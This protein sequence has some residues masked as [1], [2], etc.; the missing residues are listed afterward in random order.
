MKKVFFLLSLFSSS[1][2][3]AGSADAVLTCKSASGR[4]IFKA[5]LQDLVAFTDAAF[6]IDGQTIKYTND[7]KGHL[8]FNEKNKILTISI[9]DP[10]VGWLTFFA[11]PDTFKKVKSAP[12]SKHYKFKAVIQGKNPRPNKGQSK[13][14]VLNCELTYSI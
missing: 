3:F 7:T 8:V 12:Y 11:I 6:T 13:E 2:A 4:T 1:I 5:H 10:N 14:I 9:N